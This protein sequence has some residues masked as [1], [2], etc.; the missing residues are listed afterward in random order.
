[1]KPFYSSGRGCFDVFGEMH[2]S[3]RSD[4]RDARGVSVCAERG[5]SDALRFHGLKTGLCAQM[6]QVY[7]LLAF[8][9]AA[10]RA[11]WR[12]LSLRC[13]A[14]NQGAAAVKRRP[15]MGNASASDGQW[16]GKVSV[17]YRSVKWQGGLLGSQQSSS[18]LDSQVLAFGNR[19]IDR[20]R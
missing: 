13:K 8:H 16:E 9:E 10:R 15:R 6:I 5:L 20:T 1:M 17:D 11:L 3:D 18:R 2:G 4:E 19:V 14:P 12:S 7:V